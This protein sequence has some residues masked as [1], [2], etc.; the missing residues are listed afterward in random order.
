MFVNSNQ[1]I[2]REIPA[3]MFKEWTNRILLAK[4][5]GGKNGKDGGKKFYDELLLTYSNVSKPL[6]EITLVHHE[7]DN[8]HYNSDTYE[9]AEKA[10]AEFF[11]AKG[12]TATTLYVNKK[13]NVNKAPFTG[14]KTPFYNGSR[15][16]TT[17]F[18]PNKKKA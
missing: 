1:H 4:K 16:I 12:F 8:N 15:W 10:W 3:E 5:T 9:V 6:W 17:R 14:K 11:K 2:Q 18:V 13:E 7:K